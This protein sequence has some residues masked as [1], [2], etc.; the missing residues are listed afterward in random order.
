MNLL[1]IPSN[2]PGEDQQNERGS[3]GEFASFSILDP[4]SFLGFGDLGDGLT[5]HSWTFGVSGFGPGVVSG[6]DIDVLKHLV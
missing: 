6:F 3:R 5:V 2:N 1:F 4:P